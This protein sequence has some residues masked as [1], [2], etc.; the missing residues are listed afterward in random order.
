MFRGTIPSIQHSF[1]NAWTCGGT[2]PVTCPAGRQ[3]S[4]TCP[5]GCQALGHSAGRQASVTCPVGRHVTVTCRRTSGSGPDVKLPV[6]YQPL[7]RMSSPPNMP[8]RAS[9]P[10]D[11]PGRRSCPRVCPPGVKL[12][13]IA[14][15]APS[16][17]QATATCPVGVSIE[18]ETR[19]ARL[20]LQC[21]GGWRRQVGRD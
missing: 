8:G 4:V 5:V 16:F 10:R 19:I 9:S 18:G 15:P 3:A 1:D 17:H 13:W 11:V 2:S 20:G 21:E 7:G 14:R 12:P 6:E